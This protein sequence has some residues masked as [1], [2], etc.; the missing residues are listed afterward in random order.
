MVLLAAA[1]YWWEKAGGWIWWESWDTGVGRVGRSG[2]ARWFALSTCIY[3]RG[4][5]RHGARGGDDDDGRR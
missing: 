4:P 2:M 3:L 5:G 1:Q